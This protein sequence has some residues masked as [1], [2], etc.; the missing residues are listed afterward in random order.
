M[1]SDG[2][3]PDGIGRYGTRRGGTVHTA[4]DSTG[5]K[6]R[7]PQVV[8]H[9]VGGSYGT[10]WTG[11]NGT[12]GT[13]RYGTGRYVTVRSRT[14]RYGA[15]PHRTVRVSWQKGSVSGQRRIVL[16][17]I[18]RYGIRRGGMVRHCTARD[19]TKKNTEKHR[20][21]RTA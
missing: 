6:H 19:S 21:G 20:W 4:R 17:G 9:G 2:T 10:G 12:Y 3:G 13:A 11:W 8:S 1:G 5:K 7:K 16:D 18:E 15:G 14:L